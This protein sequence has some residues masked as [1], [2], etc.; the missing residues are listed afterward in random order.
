VKLS[1]PP[2]QFDCALLLFYRGFFSSYKGLTCSEIE[3]QG[4]LGVFSKK[5]CTAVKLKA[6]E[7]CC[8]FPP[9]EFCEDGTEPL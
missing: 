6:A 7:F 5:E 9:C 3:E 2:P 1:N 8:T 4:K